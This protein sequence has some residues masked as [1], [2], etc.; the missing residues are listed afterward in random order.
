MQQYLQIELVSR[1]VVWRPD[2]WFCWFIESFN[3]IELWMDDLRWLI[4]WSI[5]QARR[6]KKD[7]KEFLISSKVCCESILS[8]YC[9]QISANQSLFH[10]WH[11]LWFLIPFICCT[12]P[13]AILLPYI[14][15]IISMTPTLIHLTCL[16]IKLRFFGKV[17]PSLILWA[18]S[19]WNPCAYFSGAIPASS[20]CICKYNYSRSDR[21]HS[22]IY[23]RFT[24]S[25]KNTFVSLQHI[26]MYILFIIIIIWHHH[27]HHN[28][29]C[30]MFS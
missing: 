21:D 27:H 29:I 20:K 1:S 7:L 23:V 12:Q 30:V 8:R 24:V 22:E 16:N 19:V 4:N 13:V 3:V 17:K 9:C 6:G 25:S 2:G 5:D 11:E 14:E 15:P 10:K 28:H 26:L 18:R